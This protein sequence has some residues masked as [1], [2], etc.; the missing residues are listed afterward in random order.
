MGWVALAWGVSIGNATTALAG[1]SILEA[2][3]RHVQ[4]LAVATTSASTAT[5]PA[6][7]SKTAPSLA[8]QGGSTLSKSGMSKGKKVLLYA[9]LAAAFVGG[10]WAIDHKVNDITPSS[11]GTRQDK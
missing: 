4:Q 2:C 9:G 6:T 5:T 1:G 10:A 11:L 7:L 8:Y 3:G